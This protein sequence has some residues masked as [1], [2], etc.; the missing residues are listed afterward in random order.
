MSSRIN[1]ASQSA[2]HS[3]TCVSK[4]VSQLL[5]RFRPVMRRASRADDADSVIIAF[6]EFTPN[7][8]HDRRRMDLA[9]RRRG[10]VAV[11]EKSQATYVIAPAQRS[12]ACSTQCTLQ[13]HSSYLT[14]VR[15]D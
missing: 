11:L 8:E 3:Q 10:F 4:L 1:A 5:G 12:A 13:S 9:Q 14:R 7:V 15:D 2:D 6:L